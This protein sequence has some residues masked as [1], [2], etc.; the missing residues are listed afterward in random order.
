MARVRTDLAVNYISDFLITNFR[1]PFKIHQ[2]APIPDNFY[3]PRTGNSV[4]GAASLPYK[5]RR[6]RAYFPN[7]GDDGSSFEYPVPQNGGT[8]GIVAL[9][10]ALIGL[11]AECV[12][13]IGERWNLVTNIVFNGVNVPTY[14]NTPYGNIPGNPEKTSVNYIYFSDLGSAL[15]GSITLSTSYE[16]EPIELAAASA[17]C[18]QGAEEKQAASICSGSALGIKPR[19]YL[20]KAARSDSPE[21]NVVTGTIARQ[22]IISGLENAPLLQCLRDIAPSVYCSGYQGEDVRNLQNLI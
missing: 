15:G 2:D 16:S 12:D 7:V 9:S 4:C 6:L 21:S 19:R 11:G 14:R 5:T 20:W 17:Q 10:N 13:L 3:V 8:Q 22:S 1:V 18:L